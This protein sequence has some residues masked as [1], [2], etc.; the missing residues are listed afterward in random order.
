MTYEEIMAGAEVLNAYYKTINLNGIN[1]YNI[2][3]V[4][5]EEVVD[6]Y[7]CLLSDYAEKA[8]CYEQWAEI[9][10]EGLEEA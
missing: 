4:A 6:S 3:E 8:G 5:A 7:E 1:R 9:R 10:Y 2:T